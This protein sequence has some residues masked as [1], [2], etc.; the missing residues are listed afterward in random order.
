MTFL[1]SEGNLLAHKTKKYRSGEASGLAWFW[2]IV[3]TELHLSWSLLTS[4]IWALVWLK[5]ASLG[6]ANDSTAPAL[7]PHHKPYHLEQERDPLFQ[8]ST[9]KPRDSLWLDQT[10]LHT[11]PSTSVVKGAE[12]TEW[13]SLGGM[14]LCIDLPLE[15]E[16]GALNTSESTNSNQQL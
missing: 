14:T 11:Q 8:I 12:L 6:I 4:S 3:S 5:L 16:S 1:N 7:T 2:F 13:L 9:Q 10:R 15:T